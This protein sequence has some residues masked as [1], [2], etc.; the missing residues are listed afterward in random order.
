MSDRIAGLIG[1]PTDGMWLGTFHAIGGA[2]SCAVHAEL[3]GLKSN[4]TILD[5]DDQLRFDQTGDRGRA[6]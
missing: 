3:V 6:D 1:R 4:F 2:A 5:T